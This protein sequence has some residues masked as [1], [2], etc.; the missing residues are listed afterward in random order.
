MR[1]DARCRKCGA[2]DEIEK[3]MSAPMPKCAECNGQMERVFTEAT[4]VH[5]AGAGFYST[6]IA[7]FEKQVGTER[8]AKF[9][10]KKD[11]IEKRA[12]AGKLTAYEKAL[13]T[14]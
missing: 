12:K 13:E 2:K 8:A 7:H 14:V 10:A 4:T 9:R 11:D 1:Y 5:Y 3:P 6:D